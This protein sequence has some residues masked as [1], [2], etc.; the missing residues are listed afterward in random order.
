MIKVNKR[1][2]VMV[3]AILAAGILVLANV[4]PARPT[5]N[6]RISAEK[7]MIDDKK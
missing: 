1:G 6:L 5:S 2:L 3:V 7:V 4:L